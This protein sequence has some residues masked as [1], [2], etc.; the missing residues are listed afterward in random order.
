MPSIFPI[1][2][3]APAAPPKPKVN[4]TTVPGP[5]PSVPLPNQRPTRCPRPGVCPPSIPPEK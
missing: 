1:L 3:P 5:A 2:M 4:P